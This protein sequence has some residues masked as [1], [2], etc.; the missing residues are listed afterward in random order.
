MLLEPIMQLEMVV[1]E[2]YSPSINVD[3]VRRRAEIQHVDT[4]GDNKASKS[5]IKRAS[6]LNHNLPLLLYVIRR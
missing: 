3:L 2:Q 5:F 4:R 1:A 6:L